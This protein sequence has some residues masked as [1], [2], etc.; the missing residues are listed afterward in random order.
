MTIICDSDTP[1]N[2]SPINASSQLDLLNSFSLD[3]PI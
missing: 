3:F 1:E 2:I